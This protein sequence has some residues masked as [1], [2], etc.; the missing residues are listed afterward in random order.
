MF[1]APASSF[2]DALQPVTIATDIDC[3]IDCSYLGG[4]GERW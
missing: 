1:S 2:C 3:A 4:V